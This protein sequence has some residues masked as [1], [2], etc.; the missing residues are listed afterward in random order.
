MSVKDTIKLAQAEGLAPDGRMV[1]RVV[2]GTMTVSPDLSRRLDHL[3]D[4]LGFKPEMTDEEMD[5][6]TQALGELIQ[7]KIE[8]EREA[9]VACVKGYA[10]D[11]RERADQLND[12]PREKAF[13]VRAA[14]AMDIAGKIECGWGR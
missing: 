9:I 8:E 12:P 1:A 14:I 5:V 13:L 7:A 10:D 6:R 3:A 4:Q 11:C 2:D